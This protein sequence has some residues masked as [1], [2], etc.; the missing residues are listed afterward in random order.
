VTGAASSSAIYGIVNSSVPGALSMSNNTIRG[1][2]SSATTGGLYGVYNSGAVV[3]TVN[4]NNNHIGDATAGAIT[5]SAVTS[6]AIYG[7]YNSGGAATS[8][9]SLQNNDVRGITQTVAGSNTHYYVYNSAG[10]LSINISNNTF[11][12]LIANTTGSVYF[13]YDSVSS[14]AGGSKTISGN[15]IATAFSKTGA[16]GSFYLYY[17]YSGSPAGTTQANSNNNFS[18][19]TVT[20]ATTVY[21][22]YNGDGGAPTKTYQG[23][24]FANWTCGTS[25]VT[26]M[27]LSY[28]T[29]ATVAQNTIQNITGGGAITGIA[30]GGSMTTVNAYQ[31]TIGTLASTGASAVQGMTTSSGTTV[32]LYKNKIYDLSGS[33]ASTTV[34]GMLISGGTTVTATNNLIGDLRATAATATADVVRGISVTSTTA[35][36]TINLYDNTIYLNATSSGANFSTSGVYHTTST[37]ATTAALNMRGNILVNRSTPN[38]TGVTAAYR[39]SSTTLTNYAST[40]NNNLFY[41]GVPAANRLIF[42]DGTNADQTLAAYQARVT[43]RDAN[44]IWENPTFLSTVG[45]NPSFLHIDPTIPTQIESGGQPIA[46]VT[47]DYDGDARNASTPDIGADEGAFPLA[48][49]SPPVI[50]YTP[51]GNTSSTSN[52]SFTNVA[53]TDPSGVNGTA[54]TR[55]RVYYKKSGDANTFN[56]NTSGTA[57]WKYAEANGSTSF[58]D[59]T[60]DY[61]LLNSG[62]PVIGDVIQYFV[63]AQDLVA[64]PN[65]GI[66]SGTFATPPTSVNLQPANFPIGGTIRSYVIVDVPLSGDYTVGTALFAR[67]SGVSLTFE[68]RVRTVTR[69]VLEP[70]DAVPQTSGDKSAAESFLADR[71]SWK[72]VLRDVE[73]VTWVPMANGREFQ[74]DLHVKRSENA[75]LLPEAR[76]GVYATLTAAVA[77]LNA[78]GVSGP[79]RFLLTDA[80]YPSE[81]FPITVNVA[82]ENLPSATN[83]VTIKPD[84]SVVASISGAAASTAILKIFSTNYVTIDGSNAPDGTTRDLTLQNTSTTGPLVVWFGSSGTTP[85]TNDALKN[86]I[87]RN[88]VNTSSAVVIS[89]GTTSGTAGFFS[90][91]EVRNNLIDLAYIGVYATG[92]TTPAGGAGLTYADNR[93]D[94][95]GANAIRLVGLYMQGVNGAT[96]SNNTVANIE[97]VTAENDVGIW[98]A[99]GVSN[100]TV[101]GNTVTNLNYTGTSG[102][103]PIGIDVTSGVVGANIGVARN[104]VTALATAGSSPVR[105]IGSLTSTTTGVVIERNNVSGITNN[106]TGTYGAY[107]IDVAAGNNHTVKN[108][109]VSDVRFNM[110]GG[111][112]FSTTFGVFGIRIASGTGHVVADNSVNLFGSM[113][114]TSAS[115]LLSAALCVVST[116]STGCDIR[117]NALSNTLTGGTTSIAHVSAC[118]PSGGTSAMNLTWNNNGYFSGTDALTQGIAQVGT[119]AGTGFYLAS[120]FNPGATT[121]ATN[122]RA[123]TSTLSVAGTNDN[124]SFATTSAAPFTTTT[125]LHVLTTVPTP[126]ESGGAPIAGITE[127]YDGEARNASTPD[128]GADEGPFL[129]L[130]AHDIAAIAFVDP[131]NGGTKILGASFSPQASFQN[132]G[133]S[134]E[135]DVPVRFRIVDSGSNEI[136]NALESIASMPAGGNPIAHVFASTAINSVGNYTMYAKAELVGDQV[137]SNDQIVGTFSV[138][139]PLSGNYSVGAAEP[140]PYNTLTGAI[141]ALSAAGISDNVTFTL[142]DASYGPS[143]T[144]PLTIN[145][146]PGASP[147]YT[148]TIKPANPGTTISGSSVSAIF[149]LNGADYVVIDG[150]SGARGRDLTI[151]NT[152]AAT[153]TAV[154]WLKSAGAGA[155]CTYD[156]VKNCVLLAGVDQSASTSVTFGI[157][158]SD[159]AISTSSYGYDNDYNTFQGNEI[160]KVTW[161]IFLVGVSGNSND[162]NAIRGNLVGPA[163]FGTEEVGKGGIVVTY[164]NAATIEQNEVRFVGGLY[165]DTAYQYDRVG[166]G[167]GDMS[168][169]PSSSTITNSV[170]RSNLIHDIVEEKTYSAVGIEVCG[171]GTPTNNQIV[172]NMIYGVRANGTGGDQSIGIGI[173]QGDGDLVAYNS[174]SLSGDLD[175][176]SSSSASYSGVGIRIASTTPANLTLK[177]NILAVDYTS[178]T[179]TL[180]HFAIVAPAT[181]YLWGTGGSDNNDYY[182]IPTNPQMVL[183]GIGTSIPYTEVPTLAGWR[184]TFTPNQDAASFVGDPLYVGATNLHI[185]TAGATSPVANAGVPIVGVTTDYDGDAR[186]ATPDVGA[187]EFTT[188]L[189]A[190]SVVGGG[191]I[192]KAPSYLSYNPGSPVLLTAV[193]DSGWAFEEWTGDL[194]GSDNPDTLLMDGDK[195]VTAHFDNRPTISIADAS[196]TEGT[197]NVAAFIVTLTA[198]YADTVKVDFATADSTA[199]AGSDYFAAVGQLV[200]N[201]G[202]TSDTLEVTVIPDSLDEPD[203]YFKLQLS[204]ATN[205]HLGDA[206][207]I[208]TI[209]DDDGPSAAPE[210]I[211]AVTFLG[212]ANPNPSAHGAMVR[213]GL[214]RDGSVK[215]CIFDVQGR[216]MRNLVS[217]RQ[218]AGYKRVVWD[219]RDQGGNQVG[220]GLYLLRMEADRKVYKSR[221]IVVR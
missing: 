207:A 15:S 29:T 83:T 43:P 118:L 21:G 172:N 176:G 45:S 20:G 46:G 26:A 42:Y 2:T 138:L 188:Y 73:E 143:E 213:Y 93:L 124:A 13:I 194:T 209:L 120:N 132:V 151:R 105:G 23:N 96:V 136:Y 38:G 62:A 77:D 65:V 106:S 186:T 179:A 131:T 86:C 14:A 147:S 4:L 187:D 195:S 12:N 102:Y 128:I 157:V 84:S 127:D 108:N 67:A 184:A 75:D 31:N 141:G 130:F 163:A 171:T 48:D 103:A 39:R 170:V 35:S 177:D 142:V 162:N 72:K 208:G 57:G 221:M 196:V 113:L 59:F 58:F 104:S 192:T 6:G 79:V 60:V 78:R 18:N 175:P 219:G 185:S 55:P 200:I 156:Q 190:T 211:P 201:P 181:T 133:T 191:S 34:N 121:P 137:V 88:G 56:D 189:L 51:L 19:I 63:V 36:S 158:S 204:N 182:P 168:W 210:L 11:T 3:N 216:L 114:G 164:Q 135:T 91:L 27:T 76:A 80:T 50:A 110:T 98:L 100:A 218:T 82:N 193:P 139:G 148:V 152:S 167:L 69:E 123:Y 90:N 116:G 94:T 214:H 122:L 1:C 70:E 126:L 109:F 155:G 160:R 40:S 112:A 145:P 129:P 144:F 52:R 178:N 37:T 53:V 199:L 149:V 61:S 107:G 32:N 24:T 183:G 9:V 92:G 41:G 111:A 16:G 173:A 169:S 197:R 25:A 97:G 115:S 203:E 198:A 33:N 44:S 8:S 101:S 206:R 140:V 217:G 64:T 215:L 7:V 10:A 5:F 161:G 81:T 47:D 99:T 159:G 95:S 202:V 85:I 49:F 153:G 30:L 166:I 28:A 180:K 17:N 89:D 205:A 87:V 146:Y 174:I 119:T 154:I 212:G 134:S 71:V 66:N 125:D 68:R 220:A 54:G 74:G 150:S 22:W 165:A 117:D